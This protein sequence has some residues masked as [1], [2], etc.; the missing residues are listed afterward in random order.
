[1]NLEEKSK[2][3]ILIPKS[4]NTSLDN[5][6][7]EIECTKIDFIR[8]AFNLMSEYLSDR[9]QGWVY[10]LPKTGRCKQ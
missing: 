3:T 4:L 10:F 1:M 2:K 6:L 8:A 5:L 9:E 7:A